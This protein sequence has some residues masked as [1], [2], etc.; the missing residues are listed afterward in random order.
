MLVFYKCGRRNTQNC[1]KCVTLNYEATRHLPIT[2]SLVQ[3]CCTKK[4]ISTAQYSNV[5]RRHIFNTSSENRSGKIKVSCKR[6][7]L[8]ELFLLHCSYLQCHLLLYQKTH[9]HGTKN[10]KYLFSHNLH[11]DGTGHLITPEKTLITTEPRF[12]SVQLCLVPIHIR[13]FIPIALGCKTAVV[14]L[15]PLISES[16]VRVD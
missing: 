13:S 15:K 5:Q 10:P 16:N 7:S 4:Y 12:A 3:L 11:R 14:N 8:G 6:S 2:R 1:R 9:V